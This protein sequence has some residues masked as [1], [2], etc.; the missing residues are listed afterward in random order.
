ME[1]WSIYLNN[2]QE[3]KTDSKET[4]TINETIEKLKANIP[5]LTRR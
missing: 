4:L 1:D 3:D 2:L 5:R